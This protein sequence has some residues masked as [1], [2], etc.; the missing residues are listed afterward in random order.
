MPPPVGRLSRLLR[1]GGKAAEG[2]AEHVRQFLKGRQFS[3]ETLND[4]EST[5]GRVSQAELDKLNDA[6]GLKKREPA[7]AY[8]PGAWGGNR[9]FSGVE[10][11]DP[12]DRGPEGLAR[13]AFKAPNG[14]PYNVVI[15][16]SADGGG[17]FSVR[18]EHKTPDRRGQ[19]AWLP[20]GQQQP[21]WGNP[22]Y[23]RLNDTAPA[24]VRS[25]YNSVQDAITKDALA[26]GRRG[27]EIT[28]MT[29]R[30]NRLHG[31]LA[32]RADRRGE[33]P[34][35]YKATRDDGRVKVARYALPA[36][37]SAL[38]LSQALAPGEAEAGPLKLP[39]PHPYDA[40]T[41]FDVPPIYRQGAPLKQYHGSADPWMLAGKTPDASK[42]NSFGF[43][44]GTK[45][46]AKAITGMKPLVRTPVE[47]WPPANPLNKQFVGKV[48]VGE[49]RE[50]EAPDLH[51]WNRNGWL[52]ALEDGKVKGLSS[53]EKQTLLSQLSRD[54]E[55]SP[56][57]V[58]AMLNDMGIQRVKYRN[59]YEGSKPR[60]SY[61]ILDTSIARPENAIDVL[62]PYVAGGAG[63]FALSYPN[64]AEGAP[65]G[66][67]L[68]NVAGP[69][70]AGGRAPRAP[71]AGPADRFATGNALVDATAPKQI[72]DEWANL[73]RYAAQRQARRSDRNFRATPYNTR[74]GALGA[75]GDLFRGGDLPR[76]NP[77]AIGSLAAG[78]AVAGGTLA[79]TNLPAHVVQQGVEDR[80][81]DDAQ[82]RTNQL[83]DRLNLPR[84]ETRGGQQRIHPSSLAPQET[85]GTAASNLMMGRPAYAEKTTLAEMA[86]DGLDKFSS[87]F[88][89]L[90]PAKT[91]VAP[92]LAAPKLAAGALRD[93]LAMLDPSWVGLPIA[94]DLWGKR[95]GR[96]QQEL[97]GMRM[98][99]ALRGK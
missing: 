10:K 16:P 25:I 14:R 8:N 11:I 48:K 75:G 80:W 86:A 60:D 23:E 36:A 30:L 17:M 38:A 71:V 19:N 93:P 3:R 27:Y 22:Q 97:A 79:A 65:G 85:V 96:E 83:F 47:I 40:P 24:D 33:L 88:D 82:E 87:Q 12:R 54:E 64:D 31:D 89:F 78:G 5:H 26:Y 58:A 4:Y 49:G 51:S 61:A 55:I 98:Q 72:R 7:P 67:F 52:N 74:V 2:T 13:Y 45:E 81:A 68:R 29:P 66:S 34:P 43:H 37:G 44:V 46:Q 53:D 35:D 18:L 84:P 50:I 9:D 90:G 76:V 42:A 57:G 56:S 1:G 39:K 41:L 59:M 94:R 95:A 63:A 92:Y 6:Y 99:Q 70:A 15:E 62:K 20:R 91:A 21:A 73:D 32:M 77:R 69:L 28:G